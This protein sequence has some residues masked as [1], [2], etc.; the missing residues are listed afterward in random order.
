MPIYTCW[1]CQSSISDEEAV[2]E[3]RSTS[4]DQWGQSYTLV[5]VHNDRRVCHRQ[6]AVRNA[7]Q[8]VVSSQ[9]NVTRLEAELDHAKRKLIKDK[10]AYDAIL[11]TNDHGEQIVRS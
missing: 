4:G 6:V 8:T 7:M 5:W 2:L 9:Y 11:S 1:D 10:V 3:S